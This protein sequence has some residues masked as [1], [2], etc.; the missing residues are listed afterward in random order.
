MSRRHAI[1]A[2][3]T[4]AGCLFA[5]LTLLATPPTTTEVTESGRSE[6][7]PPSS[8]VPDPA[9]ARRLTRL[10]SRLPGDLRRHR[11]ALAAEG[12]TVIDGPSDLELAA[13]SRSRLVLPRPY[14]VREDPGARLY[15]VARYRWRP[16]NRDGNFHY[17]DS[18]RSCDYSKPCAVGGRDGFG[19]R[20]SRKVENLSVYAQF[21]GRTGI[22]RDYSKFSCAGTRRPSFNSSRGATFR[23]QD[24]VFRTVYKP[25]YNMYRGIITLQV[26]HRRCGVKT[27]IYSTYAHG[28]SSTSLTGFSIGT[29]SFGL[30]WSETSHRWDRASQSGTWTA[31]QV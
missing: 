7:P 11:D 12:F 23:R 3:S 20:F 15:A 18:S 30:S 22:E 14:M 5:G 8:L 1:A 13:S 16:K 27:Q 31:C 29:S 19:V 17:F 10:A 9:S 24:K 21:C 6:A 26:G 4:L 28:W 25:D 2:R